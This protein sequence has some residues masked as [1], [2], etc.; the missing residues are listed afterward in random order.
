MTTA[1]V[2]ATV[3]PLLLLPQ[4]GLLAE[5]AY[6]KATF[7]AE[8]YGRL[9]VAQAETVEKSTTYPAGVWDGDVSG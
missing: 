7:Y 2:A 4:G 9:S 6:L 1:L 5:A 8:H 3:V